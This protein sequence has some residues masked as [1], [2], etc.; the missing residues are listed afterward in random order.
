M[1]GQLRWFQHIR[2]M[3][4]GVLFAPACSSPSGLAP[5]Q[6]TR[7]A[8]AA[9]GEK[10]GYLFV[11]SPFNCALREPQIEALNAQAHRT[12]RSGRILTIGHGL[13]DTATARRAVEALGIDM[14]TVAL[15]TT[16]FGRAPETQSLGRPLAIAIR[17]GQVIAILSGADAGRI[18]AWIA[19]LE[20]RSLPFPE[21]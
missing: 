7:Q 8:V 19:W 2:A 9:L 11:F 5:N 18:D 1:R 4:A 3:S 12:R 10:S 6:W 20:H 14:K 16:P 15:A 13:D 21:Q 17:D